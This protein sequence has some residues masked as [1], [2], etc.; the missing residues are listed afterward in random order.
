MTAGQAG[1]V[2]RHL[3]A[4]GHALS[5][6]HR[7]RRRPA[8]STACST[9]P[10]SPWAGWRCRRLWPRPAGRHRRR[11]R[12][13]RHRSAAEHRGLAP[14]A[15]AGRLT[16][17]RHDRGA[18]ANADGAVHRCAVASGAHHLCR[19]GRA[20][21]VAWPAA[22]WL[23][24]WCW[25]AAT[26]P[27]ST[28]SGHPQMVAA[29]TPADKAAQDAQLAAEAQRLKDQEELARLRAEN[30]RRL[31]AEQEA[32]LRKQ[33]EEETRRKIEAEMAGKKHQ[34]EA[35]AAEKKR[36]EDEA[37]QKAETGAASLRQAE[38]AN[39]KGG[40]SGRT[41]PAPDGERPAAHPGRAHRAGVRYARRGRRVRHPY[42]RDDRGLAEGAWGSAHRLRYGRTESSP[43]EG[44][45][46]GGFPLR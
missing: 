27:W 25:R 36:Q 31:R 38:E 19:R 11:A 5:R 22:P 8:P 43:A 1:P 34:E 15:E 2:D 10:T 17:F 23:R 39:Q 37:R 7:E 45:G 9:M 13:P 3:R 12:G 6:H 21:S 35:A 18:P 42:A 14:D 20:A 41:R 33:V 32:A 44:S 16:R 26:T 30:E 28:T 40:R 24:S 4:V 46:S 29:P